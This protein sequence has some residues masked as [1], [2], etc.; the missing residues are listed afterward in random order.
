MNMGEPGTSL[1]TCTKLVRSSS[2]LLDMRM[3]FP[4]PPGEEGTV[5]QSASQLPPSHPSTT[6]QNTH[7]LGGLEHDGVADAVRGSK[8]LVHRADHGLLEGLV[9]DGPLLRELRRQAITCCCLLVFVGMEG[10][11]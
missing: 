4:P 1:E 6:K 10:G 9:W 11:G 7:T 3:P 2:S 5:S 8:R